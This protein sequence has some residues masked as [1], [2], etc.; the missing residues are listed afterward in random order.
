MLEEMEVAVSGSLHG[1]DELVKYVLA[2]YAVCLSRWSLML[3][4]ARK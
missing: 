2:D 4:D 3:L 1:R